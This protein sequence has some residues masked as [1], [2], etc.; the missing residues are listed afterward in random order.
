MDMFVVR[1][2]RRLRGRVRVSGAKNAALPIMAAAL[3][4]DGPTVLH[5]VPDLVDV[6]TLGE[7]LRSLGMQ[8]ERDDLDMN[9][10]LT[11]TQMQAAERIHVLVEGLWKK[12]AVQR[13]VYLRA[14]HDREAAII[15]HDRARS[16]LERQEAEGRSLRYTTRG[17]AAARPEGQRY[18]A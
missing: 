15:D 16:M 17:Y 11:L 9:L 8:V 7:L 5:G 10:Q 18:G 1:G 6:R 12:E 14:K 3:L 2:G 4:A 13:V